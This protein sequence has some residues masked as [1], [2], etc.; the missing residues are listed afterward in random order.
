MTN[1]KKATE[2]DLNE[3]HALV[4]QI[5]KKSL[6]K[7]EVSEKDLATAI[8]FLKDNNISADMEFNPNL[9]SLKTTYDEVQ[10]KVVSKTLPFPTKAALEN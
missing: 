1:K 10:H 5:I 8:K 3:I 4:A 2:T 6:A 9:G 7:E